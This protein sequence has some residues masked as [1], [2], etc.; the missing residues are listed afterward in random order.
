MKKSILV[1]FVILSGLLTGLK[2]YEDHTPPRMIAVDKTLFIDMTEVRNIDYKVYIYWIKQYKGENS[3]EYLNA[4]PDT[5][6][7]IRISFPGNNQIQEMDLDFY[8][9]HPNF[10]NYPVVSIS[11]EQA[12]DYCKWR[13]D[14]INEGIYRQNNKSLKKEKIPDNIPIIYKLRLP[15]RS[16]WIKVAK[17]GIDFKYKKK[18]D[19][20]GTK[21]EIIEQVLVTG[22]F[23]ENGQNMPVNVDFGK[24][25]N[26]GCYNIYG[27]V[28]EMS[29]NKGI[30]FG[31]CYSEKL[32]D[33]KI[34]KEYNYDSPKAWIG[35]RCVAEKIEN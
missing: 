6:Q 15:T 30:A 23:F 9:R 33:F 27:N 19:K 13:T 14:I 3:L 8:F 1:L 2:F 32:S 17:Q 11:Y 4:L 16:E 35:F 31:G 34:D 12:I 22:N 7:K 5:S 18:F 25:N 20:E 21:Y 26:I 29:N 28:A 10:D 24:V